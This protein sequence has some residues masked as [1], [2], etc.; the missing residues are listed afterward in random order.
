MGTIRVFCARSMTQAVSRITDEFMRGSGHKVKKSGLSARSKKA[1]TAK[2][3][4]FLVLG[5]P[6]MVTM[7]KAGC[8]FAGRRRG[9]ACPQLEWRVRDGTSPPD[10][11]TEGVGPWFQARAIAVRAAVVGGT[12]AV[13]LAELFKAGRK[14]RRGGARET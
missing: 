10:I 8:F 2:Q 4:M 12:A 7:E 6:A 9:G 5:A 1:T 13:Y 14:C 3:R 11:S